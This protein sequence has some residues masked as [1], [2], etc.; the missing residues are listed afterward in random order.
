MVKFVN[1]FGPGTWLG[2]ELHDDGDTMYGLADLGYSEMGSWSLRELF[3]HRFASGLTIGRDMAFSSRHP[4][5]T[6]A[7]IARANGGI[8]A[9]HLLLDPGAQ[10][11]MRKRARGQRHRMKHFRP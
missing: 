9:A 4:I 6:W 7:R 1:P 5:S 11:A 3:S 10:S 2:T 8:E